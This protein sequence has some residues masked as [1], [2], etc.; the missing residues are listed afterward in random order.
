MWIT[1]SKRSATRG[2]GMRTIELL[3]SSED[4]DCFMPRVALRLHGVIHMEIL[5]ISTEILIFFLRE[6]V[7]K[8]CA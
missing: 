7:L 1:P 6:I 4:I 2:Y 8:L 5:R 3:R